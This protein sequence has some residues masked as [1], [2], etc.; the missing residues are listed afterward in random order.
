L[1]QGIGQRGVRDDE[2]TCVH[3][4][5]EHLPGTRGS[6]CRKWQIGAGPDY[7]F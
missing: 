6:G 7:D 2:N 4:V 5:G 3:W 1:P